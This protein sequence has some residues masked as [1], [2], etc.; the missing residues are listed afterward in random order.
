[1]WNT[2]CFGLFIVA[3]NNQGIIAGGQKWKGISLES[4]LILS[5]LQASYRLVLKVS[6][7]RKEGK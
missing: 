4:N 6:E 7:E 3:L 1:M 2:Y 5:V